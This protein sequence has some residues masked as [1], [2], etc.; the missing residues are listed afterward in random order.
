[1]ILQLHTVNCDNQRSLKGGFGVN[2][3]EI[4]PG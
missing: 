3:V 4:G 2:F 1:M